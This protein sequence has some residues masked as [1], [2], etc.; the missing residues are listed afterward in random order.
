MK[1]N[2]IKCQFLRNG[3]PSGHEY[4]YFTPVGVAVG[5]KVDISISQG[6][7]TQVDVPVEE[8]EPFKDKAKTILGKSKEPEAAPEKQEV[9]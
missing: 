2:V 1:T 3:E 5:D 9:L 6:I 8:I 4:T 7:V